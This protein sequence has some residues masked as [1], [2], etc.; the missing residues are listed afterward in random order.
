M[1][2]RHAQLKEYSIGLSEGSAANCAQMNDIAFSSAEA[3][4]RSASKFAN[5]TK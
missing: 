5:Q 4:E 3:G 2:K 1:P